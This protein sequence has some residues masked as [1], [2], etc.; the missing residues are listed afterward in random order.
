MFKICAARP[1]LRCLVQNAPVNVTATAAK[2]V[3]E[4]AGDLTIT[5]AWASQTKITRV[6]AG[7]VCVVAPQRT[8]LEVAAE[9]VRIEGKIEGDPVDV[10]A[11]SVHCDTLRGERVSVAAGAENG[12]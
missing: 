7:G 4:T 12:P 11:G 1:P 3:C 10:V 9:H 6:G 2:L 8:S 5:S